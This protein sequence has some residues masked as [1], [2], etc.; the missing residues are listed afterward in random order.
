MF[1]FFLYT[2]LIFSSLSRSYYSHSDLLGGD[3]ATRV[4]QARHQPSWLQ[5]HSQKVENRVDRI[6]RV[7]SLE[8]LLFSNMESYQQCALEL[9]LR[10]FE[11]ESDSPLTV[12]HCLLFLFL[13]FFFFSYRMNPGFARYRDLFDLPSARFLW[14]SESGIDIFF[15]AGPVNFDEDLEFPYMNRLQLDD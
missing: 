8:K 4:A 13:F 15:P 11:I 9:A 12:R 6:K 3:L 14:F 7:V 1:L 10:F 5:C 2:L